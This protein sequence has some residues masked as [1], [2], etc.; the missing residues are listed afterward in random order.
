MMDKLF[1]N[2]IV[3]I[4]PHLDDAVLSCGNLLSMR[5]DT[6]VI[7]V[8]AGTPPNHD[9]LT[10]WDAA[11]GFSSAD[12][13]MRTRR[14]EDR[15]AL[16]ML[17]ARPRWLEF[18]DSQYGGTPSLSAVA[19]ALSE[20]FSELKPDAVLFPAG[21]FHS[22][23]VLVHKAIMECCRT[24]PNVNWLM[25]EEATYRRIAGMLQRR[26]RDLLG[27]GRQATPAPGICRTSNLKCDALQCYTSQLRA[28]E[29]KVCDGYDDALAPES[30]WVVESLLAP[31]EPK[32]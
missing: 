1:S 17:A 28:L 16:G 5:P 9:L 13:A 10:S 20:A 31:K 24:F 23:H 21:L 14:D 19:A 22:D 7:T 2:N 30:Y 8:F 32:A 4:S 15:A 11:S 18:L 27:G 29:E 26:L 3:V 6:T 12:E 25:Y